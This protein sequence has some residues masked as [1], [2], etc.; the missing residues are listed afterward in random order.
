M[1]RHGAHCPGD[2]ERGLGP[3]LHMPNKTGWGVSKRDV[4]AHAMKFKTDLF[5]SA[6][7]QC[8]FDLEAFMHGRFLFLFF[9]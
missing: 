7:E 8:S 1:V 5:Q 6:M 3:P 2:N 9:S 4:H